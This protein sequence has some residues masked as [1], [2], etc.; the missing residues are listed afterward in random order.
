MTSVFQLRRLAPLQAVPVLVFVLLMVLAAPALEAQ[1]SR[2]FKMATTA[3]QMVPLTNPP[4]KNSH[5]GFPFSEVAADTDMIT[6]WAEYIGIPF[7][8]FAQTSA[9][10]PAHPWAVFMTDKATAINAEGKEVLLQ[11]G[12]VR[13]AIV[14]WASQYNGEVAIQDEWSG[15]CYDFASPSGQAIGDAYVNY[16]IWMAQTFEPAYLVN[17]IEANLY[18]HECGGATPSWDALVTIQHRAYDAVKALYPDMPVFPSIKIETLYGQ[19]LDGFDEEEYQ[20]MTALKRDRF[21]MSVYPFG[22]PIPGESR[23]ATPYDLPLDYLVRVSQLHPEEKPLVIT[24]TGWNSSPI[25]IGDE[26]LCIENFPYS[27]E[28][29]VRDY[30]GLVFAS[31]H[32]G[33]FEFVN[34]WSMRDS[35]SATAQNTCY[36]RDSAPFAACAGDPWCTIINFVKDHTAAGGAQLFGELVQKAFGSFGMRTYDGVERPALMQRWRDERALPLVPPPLPD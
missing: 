17:F 1:T 13:T 16:A 12:F 5:P 10:D 9:I 21:G 8:E 34:W 20:A 22:V 26:E 32:F 15:V 23:L 35:M 29:W 19:E 11:L 28:A 31:A 33:E 24:E 4:Y 30:M 3:V 18:Y 2:P 25:R 36:M 7:V 27:E 14:S 6:F